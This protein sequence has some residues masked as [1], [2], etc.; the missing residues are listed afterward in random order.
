MLRATETGT[1]GVVVIEGEPGFGKTRLVQE[2]RKRFMAWVGA[3]SGRLL[4][5]AEGCCASYAST[6]PY[7]LYRHLLASWA[8]VGHD[9]P[10]AVVAPALQRATVAVMG[11]DELWPVLARMMDE[12]FRA[13]AG[14]VRRL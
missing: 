11:N 2:C 1:S 8:G 7:G 4:L 13:S 12:V 3:G 14:D 5:W 6:T 10:E 9:Q